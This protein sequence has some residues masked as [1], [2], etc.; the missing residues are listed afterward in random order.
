M[1]KMAATMRRKPGMALQEFYPYIEHIHGYKITK[2]NPLTIR[3]Y[4]QN[5]VFDSAYGSSADRTYELPIPRDSVT[6]LWFD[7]FES[8]VETFT[9]PYVKETVGPDGANFADKNTELSLVARE[10]EY[11]VP[12]AGKGGTK[13]LH[14]LRKTDSLPLTDF[15]KQWQ[16]AHE[17]VMAISEAAKPIRRYVQSLQVPEGNSLLAYFSSD[18]PVYEGYASF[19]YDDAGALESFRAYQRAFETTLKDTPFYLP[20]QSFF[21]MAREVTIVET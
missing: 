4:I 11:S 3:R 5:H 16:S 1:I 7:S 21:L 8:M 15:F 12:N 10:V 18:M 2:S 19:W 14:F 20:S 17:R 9:H 6:E 13:V